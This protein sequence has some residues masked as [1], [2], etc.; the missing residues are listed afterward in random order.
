MTCRCGHEGGEPHPCHGVVYT[1]RKPAIHRFY[2]PKF[3]SL[4]G[5]QMKMEVRDTW[6]CDECWEEFKF[7]AASQIQVMKKGE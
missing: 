6:A 4:A 5:Q 1:C 2:A 7:L 3:V